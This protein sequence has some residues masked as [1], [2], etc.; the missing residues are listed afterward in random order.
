MKDS[1]KQKISQIKKEINHYG[2]LLHKDMQINFVKQN[3]NNY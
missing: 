2:N 3:L 1:K